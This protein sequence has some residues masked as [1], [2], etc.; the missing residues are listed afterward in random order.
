VIADYAA[1]GGCEPALD[2]GVDLDGAQGFAGIQNARQF[3][4]GVATRASTA[5]DMAPGSF[6]WFTTE[7]TN[8]R[9]STFGFNAAYATWDGTRWRVEDGGSGCPKLLSGVQAPAPVHL[10]DARYKLYFNRHRSAGGPT[11][12]A[13]AIKPMQMLYADGTR[14]GDP[15]A[16]EFEDWEPLDAARDVNYVWPDGT[17]L[18][19]DEESRLD[20]Y[21][22]L[23]PL[24]AEPARLIMYSNMSSSGLGAMPFI[25][26]AVL[27]NP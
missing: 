5:W 17:L 1:G 13:A 15:V 2:I 25:G 26:A 16:V 22:M 12:P 6:M 7:W 27:I 21:V 18:S 14:S 3:K 23:A 9:C 19:E 24:A 10:G 4:I 20:D 11:N 8:G